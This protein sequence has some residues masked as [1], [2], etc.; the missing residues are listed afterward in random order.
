MQG[1]CQIK[2]FLENDNFKGQLLKSKERGLKGVQYRSVLVLRHS[3]E[4]RCNKCSCNLATGCVQ[5]PHL[6]FMCLFLSEFDVEGDSQGCPDDSD[7][8]KVFNGLASWS[9]IIGRYCGSV[10]PSSI[11]SKTNKLRIE[12]QSN[13]QY[14]GRG[15][16]A[17]FTVQSD[18]KGIDNYVSLKTRSLHD[19]T[20]QEFSLARLSWYLGH[21]T[22]ST[23]MA[24]LCV[25]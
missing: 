24:S 22:F 23:K 25:T 20:I 12:F 7:Y 21:Y 11:E 5:L 2:P 17:V 14:A 19:D 10:I 8:A 13:R 18:V 9:P 16:D 1:A 4:N 3:I 15:F 6:M